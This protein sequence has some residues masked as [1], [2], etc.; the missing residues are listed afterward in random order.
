[1]QNRFKLLFFT[2]F[3]ITLSGCTALKD[4][5]ISAP[6]YT[7]IEKSNFKID[8]ETQYY[9]MGSSKISQSG[10]AVSK[11]KA[12]EDAEKYLRKQILNES[13]RLLNS[14]FT[15]IKN[16]NIN[17]T[18]GTV[19]D[20]ANLIT[21]KLMREVKETNNWKAENIYYTVLAINK[22]KVPESIKS[23]F[24]IYLKDIVIDLNTAIDK[25]SSDYVSS[26]E[27]APPII[28][29]PAETIQS[30]EPVDSKNIDNPDAISEVPKD[31]TP[32]EEGTSKEEHNDPEVLLDEF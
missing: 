19:N 12:K 2:L 24:V 11:M 25:I 1:M 8:E 4:T 6:T 5:F 14:Y 32:K 30:V 20:L 26:E 17:I 13:T 21:S 16:N 23:T 18:K 9:A 27:V 7:E 10:E 3:I 22:N 29:E 31:E 28:S 15:E